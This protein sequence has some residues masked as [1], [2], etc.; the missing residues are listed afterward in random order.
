MVITDETD[1]S[2][3]FCPFCFCAL[4]FIAYINR[5]IIDKNGDRDQ[6]SIM[7]ARCSKCNKYHRILPSFLVPFKQ[8][9]AI[10]AVNILN[11]QLT[12]STPSRVSMVTEWYNSRL[13]KIENNFKIALYRDNDFETKFS[14]SFEVFFKFYKNFIYI[15]SVITNHNLWKI[16]IPDEY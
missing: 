7:Q 1:C 3:I 14:G 13:D 8:I 5:H 2:K 16:I 15:I 11:G 9:C 12:P 6:I 4:Y 10:L